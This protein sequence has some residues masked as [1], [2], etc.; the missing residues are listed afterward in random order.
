MKKRMQTRIQECD[1][2]PP[3]KKRCDSDIIRTI[4]NSPTD[5]RSCESPMIKIKLHGIEEYENECAN[6]EGEYGEVEG[7]DGEDG[8]DSEQ[9]ETRRDIP[10][11]S[12]FVTEQNVDTDNN[13]LMQWKVHRDTSYYFDMNLMKRVRGCVCCN[14]SQR[15]SV[16]SCICCTRYRFFT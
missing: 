14:S 12:F 11:K 4:L 13:L 1:D 8:E 2:E 6:A 9:S 3:L 15:C 10:Y 5:S 16:P 7:E